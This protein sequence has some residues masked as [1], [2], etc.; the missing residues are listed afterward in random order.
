[1]FKRFKDRLNEVSE[2]V[3][4]DPRFVNGIAS[5]NQL[6][7][8]TVSA[9]K[10]EGSNENL[11]V[12]FISGAS[13]DAQVGISQDSNHSEDSH[14]K[15]SHSSDLQTFFNQPVASSA[16]LSASASSP[17]LSSSVI[18]TP[19][20]SNSFFSLT[21]DDDAPISEQET[22]SNVDLQNPQQQHPHSSSNS[23][24]HRARRL[25]SSSMSTEAAN[26]FP[27]YESPQQIF[28]FPVNADLDSTAG[29]EWEEDAAS[30]QQRLT[31]VSKEQLFQMLQKARA[32][33]HKYKGRYTDLSKAFQDLERENGKIKGVMQQTQVLAYNSLWEPIFIEIFFLLQDKALRRIS[34]LK[35]Q[36]QLEQKAKRHLEEELRSDLEEKHHVIEALQTKVSLLKSGGKGVLDENNED[37]ATGNLVDISDDNSATSVASDNIIQRDGDKIANLEG[38]LTLQMHTLQCL[39]GCIFIEKIKRLEGLLTKCKESIKAN[40][41]KTTAL[42]EVKE[43]LAKQVGE[44]EAESDDLRSQLVNLQSTLAAAQTEISNH[45][46][47]EQSEELQIAELKLLMHQEM[48]TKDEEIGKLRLSLKSS[49]EQDSDKEKEIAQ[50]KQEMEEMSKQQVIFEQ[51]MES[52][53]A[54]ALQEISRGKSSALQALNTEMEKRL[55]DLQAEHENHQE[56]LVDNHRKELSQL[57]DTANREKMREIALKEEEMRKRLNDKEEEGKL[58]LEELELRLSSS[59]N[60]A[61]NSK[62]LISDLETAVKNLKKEKESLTDQL[63][64][65]KNELTT[66]CSS[67]QN[68][69]K[70]ELS[71]LQAKLNHEEGMKLKLME[72][73]SQL[74]SDLEKQI[75]DLQNR[76]SSLKCNEQKMI[77]YQKELQEKINQF[78]KEHC[79]KKDQVDKLQME[80][81]DKCQ[82]VQAIERR[83]QAE[84]IQLKADLDMKIRHER[85]KETSFKDLQVQSIEYQ[86]KLQEQLTDMEAKLDKERMKHKT[87]VNE[88]NANVKTLQSEVEKEQQEE[89]RSMLEDERTLKL[90]YEA[91]ITELQTSIEKLEKDKS[92][93]EQDTVVLEEHIK[94]KGTDLESKDKEIQAIRIRMTQLEEEINDYQSELSMAKEDVKGHEDKCKCLEAEN[95]ELKTKLESMLNAEMDRKVDDD[96]K[97]SNMEAKEVEMISQMAQLKEDVKSYQ[98]KF[99]AAHEE[100]S[101]LLQS[102]QAEQQKFKDLED[103]ISRMKAQ[104]DA[105][106]TEIEEKAEDIKEFEEDHKELEAKVDLAQQMMYD[107]QNAASSKDGEIEDL[108]SNLTARSEELEGAKKELKSCQTDKAAQMIEFEESLV[109]L[110]RDN[111]ELKTKVEQ[112]QEEITGQN[113]LLQE[114]QEL[115]QQQSLLEEQHE[116]AVKS[117]VKKYE[118]ALSAKEESKD[119]ELG[120]IREDHEIELKRTVQDLTTQIATLR[121]DLY[122]KSAMYDQ[123]IETHQSDIRAKQEELEDEVAHCTRM[124]QSKIGQVQSEYQERLKELEQRYQE[125]NNSWNWERATSIDEEVL[126]EDLQRTPTREQVRHT[127]T[128]SF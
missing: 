80:L 83:N 45:K 108:K 35:E 19:M 61:D 37:N 117:L 6:A 114:N 12:N 115:G 98:M 28:S 60:A 74:K 1:M 21:E 118:Q 18:P 76:E 43:S 111:A 103:E 4:R 30:S 87:I 89:L 128:L 113:H 119:L 66:V 127:H 3:K 123:V 121:Q 79:L 65:L 34:E 33:Y 22:F 15:R 51:S 16:A 55:T 107:A 57:L 67:I 17:A 8:Q 53:K 94:Q 109:G 100:A 102:M 112:L 38:K 2:E 26:L 88:L 90:Q 59:S 44:R 116:Q 40:K 99:E 42:T 110:E 48:I 93:R 46:K 10:N 31:S 85:E 11:Q 58:A 64:E 71:Q 13:D 96:T 52:E 69:L 7:Q 104:L 20:A 62:K 105:K 75:C 54:A 25:S 101:K 32:R 29:S 73:K 91:M 106:Q 95:S 72:E 122:E 24:N 68:E 9:L 63:E 14:H 41:Q 92:Q 39:I 125:E 81:E 36:C 49:M 82:E 5:V 86:K 84:I 50:L 70:E 78:E 97:V 124:Y 23:P 126:V 27:I 47:R 77:T 120:K 56:E